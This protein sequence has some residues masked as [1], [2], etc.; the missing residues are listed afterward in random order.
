MYESFKDETDDFR[1]DLN[2]LC[3]EDYEY[4]ECTD[5]DERDDQRINIKFDILRHLTDALERCSLDRSE[6]Q[7]S[8]D[9]IDDKLSYI[10]E[11][12]KDN[13]TDLCCEDIDCIV[14]DLRTQLDELKS[15]LSSSSWYDK[16]ENDSYS[17]DPFVKCIRQLRAFQERIIADMKARVNGE[18]TRMNVHSKRS[19]LT[20]RSRSSQGQLDVQDQEF[21]RGDIPNGVGG[22]PPPGSFSTTAANARTRLLR[23]FR[24]LKE[25]AALRHPVQRTLSQYSDVFLLDTW[26]LHP[27]IAVR[28]GDSGAE[29]DDQN[30]SGNELDPIIRIRRPELKPCPPPPQLLKGW[31]QPG[32]QA[33][34]SRVHVIKS[35]NF[36]ENRTERTITVRFTDND[37]RVEALEKWKGTRTRWIEAERPA[38]EARNL[39]EDVYALW[40][41]MQRDGDRVELVL[42]DGILCI[43]E[44]GIK[45]PVL[46]QRISLE[47]DPFGPEFSFSSGMEEVQLQRTLLRQ[48]PIVQASMIAHIDREL[49]SESPDPLGGV[50]TDGFL[51]RLVQGLFRDG[52]FLESKPDDAIERPALWREPVIFVR[53]RTAGLSATLDY[54]IENLQ[55]ERTEVPDGLRRIVGV[56]SDVSALGSTVPDEGRD[57]TSGRET[58]ILFCKPA[59]SE[60]REIATRL[61]TAK[62]VVVQGPPGT[63]KTHTIANLLGHLLSIG[64][65]VLVTAHTTKALR[66]LREKTV[67]AIQPLCLS[68]L[69]G[70]SESQ[71]QLSSAAQEIAARLSDSNPANLRREATSLRRRRKKLLER[72]DT[73]KRELRAARFSEIS[74]IV[75]GGDGLRPIDAAKRVKN[76][77]EKHSWIPGP[78]KAG[79]LCPLSDQEVTDLYASQGV[80][81]AY[82]ET[83]LE[84]AQP[85]LHRLVTPADFR[86]LTAERI[87]EGKRAQ[88][89]RPDLW[90]G[91]RDQC[92]AATLQTLQQRFQATAET[93]KDNRRWLREALYAGWSGGELS[94]TWQRLLGARKDLSDQAAAASLLIVEYGPKLPTDGAVDDA[95]GVLS[96]IVEFHRSGRRLGKWTRITKPSWHRLTNACKVDDRM[97]RTLEEFQALLVQANLQRDRLRFVA[98]WKRLVKAVDGPPIDGLGA[99]PERVAEVYASEIRRRLEWRKREWEPL[100]SDL[101]AAGFRWAQ[102]VENHPPMPGELGELDRVRSAVVGDLVT[103]IEGHAAILRQ[104]ELSETLQ[105]QRTYLAQFRRSEVAAQCTTAQDEW[106]VE[107]YEES[108]HE[109]A[110]LQGLRSV[111]ETRMELL[112]KLKEAAP[113]WAQAM[114]RR[115]APH[116]QATVPSH[117]K[118]AW[119]YRQLKQELARR[120]R[121]S[122]D[123]IQVEI[124]RLS[125]EPQQLAARIVDNE[126][127]AAQ[128]DRTGLKERQALLGFVQTMRKVGKATGVRAPE[129]LRRARE[130]LA[131]ARK[132]VPVWIMPLS[133]VYESFDPRETKFDV[134][135]IDEASQSDVTAL[136]ALY[137]ARTHVVV[138]DNEQVTPDAVGQATDQVQRLIDTELQNIPNKHLYDGQTSIYDLA[139]AAFGHTVALRE[140]FRCVPEIIQFSNHLS[141]NN[142]IVALREPYSASVAPGLVSQR[143]NLSSAVE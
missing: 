40:T 86:L 74:E 124:D 93:L 62:S 1:D 46:L 49:E 23:T 128:C 14:K 84:V 115:Q 47:F 138:G 118:A 24:F 83:Q 8:R 130:L 99:P 103:I 45:H 11:S 17:L 19:N 134:I 111:F 127:W 80:L 109:L 125:G 50:P 119:Q 67:E 13:Y 120:A 142:K 117:P 112:A 35:Q 97:P 42:G 131:S 15:S 92:S 18:T 94:T 72:A 10:S 133:R 95:V 91:T 110:R 136:A 87:S 123:E 141:Y 73:L 48:V 76:L 56:E 85:K 43:K 37:D 116:D 121:V 96:K 25:L 4:N 70:D 114:V 51:K 98:R 30:A 52:E 102:W 82:D 5:E 3:K 22:S 60:Q 135:V 75:I 71:A 106:D 59:N 65:S 77:A 108:Q 57:R 66:V 12:L 101:C 139:E 81:T 9:Y 63:G 122:T 129:L 29:A 39:F 53:P 55:D 16:W 132:A 69:E 36:L 79:V 28:R 90:D 38:V 78:L 88:A 126:A 143:V 7:E 113:E 20:V 54:T 27:S 33:V 34:N 6:I 58:D 105:E 68:V 104:A 107:S 31:L 140:H 137:L 61:E 89:H 64:K 100:L 44:L 26:P 32:W 21:E 2:L 41:R